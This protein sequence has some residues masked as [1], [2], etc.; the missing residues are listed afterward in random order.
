MNRW[1]LSGNVSRHISVVMCRGSQC[2][3]GC[4][5]PVGRDARPRQAG[6][7]D[8]GTF[9]GPTDQMRDAKTG[10]PFTALAYENWT[11]LV[12]SQPALA[13]EGAKSVREIGGEGQP[14]LLAALTP[15][16][17]LEG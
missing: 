10:Q 6:C 15:K 4:C 16:Q 17:D 12:G 9:H 1:P 11:S 3:D 13:T 8:L 5:G 7:I 2:G 14:P